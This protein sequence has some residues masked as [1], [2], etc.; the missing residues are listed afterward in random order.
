MASFVLPSFSFSQM[1]QESSLMQLEGHYHEVEYLVADC[2]TIVSMCLGGHINVWDTYT[3]QKTAE[4][5]RKQDT[6]QR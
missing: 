6:S 3:G 2:N 4:I 1:I 5:D